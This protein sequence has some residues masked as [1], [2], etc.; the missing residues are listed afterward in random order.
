M[1]VSDQI[2][3]TPAPGQR[4][5]AFRGDTQSFSL[6]LPKAEKGTA[7]LRTNIGH[8]RI[9]REEIIRE[10]L[11]DETRLNRD[12]FDIPLEQVDSRHFNVTVALCEVGHFE[13]KCY[14]LPEGEEDPVWPDGDNTAINIEPADTCCSNI[15]YNAFVRQFGKNKEGRKQQSR[16]I[17]DSIQALDDD[18]YAV[19]PPSGTFRDLIGELDFIVSELGCRI[20]QLLPI[21]PTPTTFARMGRFGSPYAALSF[22]TVDPA[23]A[24]FDPK[25]TPTEQFIELIDAIHERNAKV[26][27]DIAINHTGWAA[28]LHN[29][30]PEWLVRDTNGRIEAPGAWGVVWEDLT[31]LDYSHKALWQHMAEVFLLWCR[32]GVDGF[33]C[34]AGYMI[35]ATAWKYITAVVRNQFPDTVFLLEG[36]G[37]KISVTRD[38][39]NTANLNW[40]Y[41]ELFQNY[42]RMQIENYLP[43]AIEISRE[44]GIMIHF[45]ETHDNL[46]LA[47]RSNLYAQ[48]R[49][50]LCALCSQHGGFGFASGVEWFATEKIDVHRANSLNWGS[51]TNQVPLISRLN[52][53]LKIHPAFH[54]RT[55]VR[56]VQQGGGSFVALLRHHIPSGKRLLV[57]AN[58]DIE[59]KTSGAWD[60]KNA[61][62]ED[63]TFWDLIS[64]KEIQISRTESVIKCLLDPGQ[65]LC[66]TT[67]RDY[68]ALLDLDSGSNITIPDR[69]LKQSLRAKALDVYQLYHG[70]EGLGDFNPDQAA[71]DLEKNPFE[72]CRSLN[73]FSEESRVI[74]WQWPC[75]MKREV[76]V[77]PDHFLMV[78]SMTP[79]Q[80]R[81]V[82]R[83]NDNELVRVS[84][85]CLPCVDGSFFVLFLPLSV[86]AALC[87]L[88]LDL[89]RFTPGNSEKATSHLLFL[90][91]AKDAY[92]KRNFSRSDLLNR[93]LL[94]LG[95]N[96]RGGMIRAHSDW[97]KLVSK[98]DALLAANLN[99]DFPEDRW[100][101]FS[102]CRAWLVFQG[103]SIE[104]SQECI[105]TFH[106]DDNYCGYW[107]YHIP[108]GQGQD[109]FLTISMEMASGENAM[110]MAFYRHK[111]GGVDGRLA[112]SK[113]VRI[114]LR[115]DI[116][117]RNFHE[118]TKAYMGPENSWHDSINPEANGFTF[119]PAHDRRLRIKISKGDFIPEPEWQYMIHHSMEAE[120]GL[121]S[122]SDLFSPGFFTV[123]LKGGDVVSLSAEV[124]GGNQP[125]PISWKDLPEERFVPDEAFESSL[126][127]KD[128]LLSAIESYVVKRKKL[129]T[130]IAGYPWFLDWGRDTLIFV[131]GLIAAG[132]T[133]IS[134]AI[135]EQ[136]GRFEDHGT[137]PNMIRGDN[138]G[139]RDTSDAP[140][141]FFVA[142]SDLINAEGI[143]FFLDICCGERKIRH[144][145]ISIA[146]SVMAGTPDG[147]RMDSDS[148][149][150]FS[151]AHFTWM[152]TNHPPGTPREGYPIEIQALWHFALSFLARIDNEENKRFWQDKALLVQQSILD[153]FWLEKEGFLSDCLHAQ[154]DVPARKATP[155]DALRP[156]QLFA[157]TLEAV[158]D[159]TV[160]RNI[161][162]ASEELIIP[163]AIRSLAD[164][165]VGCPLP[166]F[167]NGQTINNPNRP[168][169]GIYSG[170]ED[171]Q[172]KPA[173][174]NG[175]A[176]SWVFPSFCEAWARTYGEKGTETALAWLASSTRLINSGCAG[177]VPEILDGDYPHT[178]RGCD[179]QAWGNSEL[180]RVLIGLGDNRFLVSV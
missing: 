178:Q 133:E 52:Q 168:Y 22:K 27:I 146:H 26:L 141:W 145:L 81:I 116:E 124:M 32:R 80:A 172:R 160:C 41:S 132:K 134:R 127:L 171:S 102:R 104:I 47:E 57:V 131:R 28:N 1:N 48:M 120:R 67:G 20:I 59:S 73:I 51:E 76:M 152:D 31:K 8:G 149:L 118:T 36:L 107:R 153:Y 167:Y 135:L 147:I 55:E 157:V 2:I 144:I 65:V 89:T 169:C 174:H 180:L 4:I 42:D 111:S 99:P 148:G 103:Y 156:N 162:N 6:S 106:Y 117:D 129:N 83:T 170:D 90:P 138:A 113:E 50:S 62:L 10:V 14:F 95:T 40:A 123:P 77:P 24:E 18:G 101:M 82:D 143:E 105:D 38:I 119:E 68:L 72:Y 86:P 98:Y 53:L 56:F 63:N 125:L 70:I 16:A 87:P 100:V 175:T 164:R 78:R 21:H 19:I 137:L 43:E 173:Y 154:P 79:F 163:G 179:A 54:D 25:A 35:P 140:L 37:G 165:E 177:H 7:W 176:W 85:K 84:E 64:G 71:R 44:D 5:L 161:V 151:P 155:D 126:K 15:V 29:S 142:C 61:G 108:S 139:N 109:V 58:L 13:A 33:R 69:I 17:K 112:D 97:G 74:C 91:K 150:V 122:E 114:I 94:L 136:F 88:E 92:V 49:T 93:P 159:L 3:Q 166:V 23:L 75:D 39:L 9:K 130:V 11:Y 45:A 66:L 115:P 12:W 96:G 34:D 128:A 158:T 46:R 121:D 110:R 60:K 30:N